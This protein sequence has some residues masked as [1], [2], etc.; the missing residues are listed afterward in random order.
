MAI[1]W[2]PYLAGDLIE[3]RPLQASDFEDL[4]KVA[5][6]PLIWEQHP[7]PNRYTRE[8]FWKYFE[9]GLQSKGAL[10]I[11]DRLSGEMLGSSRFYDHD[12]E[13]DQIAIG[14][15]F[16]ARKCWGKPYN[17]E[18]KKLMIEYA[19]DH[20]DNILFFIG[21]NNNRSIKAI[22]KTGAILDGR[23]ESSVTYKITKEDWYKKH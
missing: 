15:T 23:D 10:L 3:L 19:F 22:E 21:I 18:L 12:V 2:Q 9:S 17:R 4:Y 6:D 16:L 5:A 20:V 11:M 8:L 7:E 13:K 14:Y 1:N